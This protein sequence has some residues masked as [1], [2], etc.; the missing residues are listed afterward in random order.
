MAK[1]NRLDSIRTMIKAEKRVTVASLEKEF[2]VTGE[3]IRRDLEALEAEGL[4]NRTYGGAV[5]AAPHSAAAQISFVQRAQI[6]VQEKRRIAELAAT[7]IPDGRVV[8]GVDSSTTVFELL[9]HMKDNEDLLLMTYS[10]NVLN[11]MLDS[12]GMVMSTGGPLRKSRSIFYG[13]IAQ[14]TITDHYTDIFFSSCKGLDMNSGVFDTDPEEVA[15]K[16]AMADHSKKLV[17]LA[18]HSKFG[19]VAFARLFDF[20]QVHA[21]ITDA[22]PSNAWVRLLKESNVTLLYPSDRFGDGRVTNPAEAVP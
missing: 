5:L 4:V 10:L 21:I 3:T 22:C 19:T 11:E 14:K 7:L 1:K 8:I 15:L 18:D 16:Q 2:K 20:N 13:T 6:H 17:L 9:P 12:R